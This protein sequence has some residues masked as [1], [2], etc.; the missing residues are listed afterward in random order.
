MVPHV[1]ARETHQRPLEFSILTRKRLLQQYLPQGDSRTAANSSLFDH[2]VGAS[3]QRRG[4]FE[5]KSFGGLE[6]DHKRELGRGLRHFCRS[7]I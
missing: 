3:K 4:Q 2:L 1:D 5:P 6:V 7:H